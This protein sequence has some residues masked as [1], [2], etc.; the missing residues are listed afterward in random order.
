MIRVSRSH[1]CT[2][3]EKKFKRGKKIRKERYQIH[4]AFQIVDTCAAEF[5][6][7]TP[8]YYSCYGSQNEVSAERTKKKVLILG[9]GPIRIGH[10]IDL[11]IDT[12]TQGRDKSRDGFLI[13]RVSIETGV[14]CLTSLDTAKALL[15]SLES[16]IKEDLSLVDIAEIK[17]NIE[18]FEKMLDRK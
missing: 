8:Y 7:K 15:T 9:S 13:R 4:A 11:V 5:E 12:P 16:N 18:S 2:V 17:S 1:H 3:I 14:P 10:E 6:A